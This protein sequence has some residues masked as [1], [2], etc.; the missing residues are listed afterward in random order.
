MNALLPMMVLLPMAAAA[1]CL[2]LWKRGK[3]ACYALMASVTGLEA[4]FGGLLLRQALSGG[5][6]LFVIPELCGFGLTFRAD[7]FRSLYALVAGFMWLMT[8][9]FTPEYMAHGHRQGRYCAFT[10]LTLGAIQGVFLSDDLLTAFVFFEIMSFTSYLWVAHEESP[11]A[12]RA[13]ETYLAIAVFGGMAMLM[14]LM[15]LSSALGTLSFRDLLRAAEQADRSALYLP[16]ALILTG[17]G[18]KAGMFPL[19]VWLPKAHPVAPAP[20]S[21]LLSGVLTKVGI[22]G[23]LAVSAQ[24][25]LHDAPWGNVL[26]MGGLAT[27]FLGALLALFSV[28]LKRTLA[29]SSMSQIGFILVGVAMQGLLGE[30]NALAASGTVLH[31]LNH[32]LIKLILFLCA[33]VVHMRL[34]RLDLNGIRGFG[35]KK[36]L[37]H[38]CF[39]V[40]AASISG[41]PLFSGYISKTLLHESM[42]E[43]VAHLSAHGGD[44]SWYRLAETLFVVTGGMTAAYMLKLYVALFHDRPAPGAG[45]EEGGRGAQKPLSRFALGLSAA[46]LVPL[47]LL[48]ARLMTPLADVSLPFMHAVPPEHAVHF[49]SLP[50]LS[51]T[52]KSLLI[53]ALLYV[54]FVRRALAARQADGSLRYLDRWPKWLDLENAVY[55]PAVG[56]LVRLGALAGRALDRFPD[57]LMSTRPYALAARALERIPEALAA[58]AGA[59]GLLLARA[60]GH[61]PDAFATLLW[62]SVFPRLKERQPAPVGNGFTYALGRF[63]DGAARL[64]NRTLLR[65]RPVTARFT[66]MFAAAWKEMDTVI[67]RI[68]RSLS[69]SLMMFALGLLIILAYLLSR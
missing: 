24:V 9:L 68:T 26:L 2:P 23:I 7:G 54:F 51:G 41:V 50:N 63:A 34:H 60:A 44:A 39:L 49:F 35:R 4:V 66:D 28:D 10:L 65:A 25:L 5:E 37:L 61:L 30:E 42:L 38:F 67:H 14:G 21:A 13:A 18:A 57:H 20:S 22:F 47:G 16:C 58:A 15:L 55:R 53:G 19:H 8:S 46:L 36:P 6:S 17:F 64:A 31:M 40:G 69:F 52:G 1:P 32:S 48:P 27:M 45:A 29:C 33:G 43:F 59:A 62:K 3:A 11:A 56:L 12:L